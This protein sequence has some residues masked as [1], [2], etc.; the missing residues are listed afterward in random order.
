MK[1]LQ[2]SQLFRF[3]NIILGIYED[4]ILSYNA[5][6]RSMLEDIKIKLERE[7]KIGSEVWQTC[8]LLMH[9]RSVVGEISYWNINVSPMRT[10]RHAPDN[11]SVLYAR[12]MHIYNLV[13]IDTLT[14]TLRE[15]VT[16][17]YKCQNICDRIVWIS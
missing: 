1:V 2:R 8:R 6:G 13:S 4:T 14:R 16:C 9:P 3:C 15:F 10:R 17:S 7:K 5:S 12:I 11:Y